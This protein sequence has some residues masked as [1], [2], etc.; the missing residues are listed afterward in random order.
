MVMMVRIMEKIDLCS[1]SQLYNNKMKLVL[2]NE[3]RAAQFAVLLQNLKL[4]SEHITLYISDEKGIYIQGMDSSH[5]SCFEARLYP[6]WFDEFE[7][8]QSHAL[9]I[10]T[11]MIQKVLDI[12]HPKQTITMSSKGNMDKLDISFEGGPKGTMDKH[13]QLPLMMI[14]QDLMEIGG[15]DSL[16]DVT[17]SSKLFSDLIH[18]LKT[19][20]DVA[21]F[22]F[23]G[24]AITLTASG[25]EGSMDVSMAY[26]DDD[27][28]VESA[29]AEKP[30]DS[31]GSMNQSFSLRY[32]SAV[33]A[34]SK[35]SDTI[36]V[37]LGEGRPM[38][39]KYDVG[40]CDGGEECYVAFY[41]APRID[42]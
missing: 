11:V 24:D 13:F 23:T 37:A 8:S 26:A 20:A 41:L 12:R 36:F 31:W 30:D 22:S 40:E 2:S 3:T 15:T 29:I 34:F 38:E 35:L 7:T 19:F 14:E 16:V 42:D 4:F 5:C 6:T 25:E 17:F 1:I 18:Q 33:S 21:N 39:A 9:G 32:I 10:S 28:I 27:L